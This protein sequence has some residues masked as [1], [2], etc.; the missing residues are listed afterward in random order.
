MI[1]EEKNIFTEDALR[2]YYKTTDDEEPNCWVCDQCIDGSL[3]DKCGPEYGWYW[4]RRSL[5]PE[6]LKNE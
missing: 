4:Y 6:E 3:C 2:K 1:V 5:M